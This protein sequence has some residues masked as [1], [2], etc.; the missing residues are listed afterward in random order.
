MHGGIK[1][2]S[3]SLQ[4]LQETLLDGWVTN[5]V[6]FY[7]DSTMEQYQMVFW[8]R[9]LQN[10]ETFSTN[11]IF[12]TA[13]IYETWYYYGAYRFLFLYMQIYIYRFF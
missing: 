5:T 8:C 3:G 13:N 7:R 12:N 1:L 9:C 11:S 2:L 4:L 10:L 6:F